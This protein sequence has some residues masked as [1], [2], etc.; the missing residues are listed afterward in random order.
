VR[1]KAMK[2]PPSR[3]QGRPPG[4]LRP[5]S[6]SATPHTI[7]ITLPRPFEGTGRKEGLH[8]QGWKIEVVS[9][10]GILAGT[11]MMKGEAGPINSLIGP[12]TALDKFGKNWTVHRARITK[13]DG[14]HTHAEP[15][16]R[17]TPAD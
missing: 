16:G 7:L 12:F 15:V 17:I 5:R 6:L 1:V 3:Q 10:A 13:F 11:L 9:T 2:P 14:T 8:V 4:P